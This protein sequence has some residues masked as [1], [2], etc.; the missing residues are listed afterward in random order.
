MTSAR[1][2][3]GAVWLRFSGCS[4]RPGTQAQG[5]ISRRGYVEDG[6]C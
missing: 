1:L 5:R 4:S 3:C 2:Q 6:P